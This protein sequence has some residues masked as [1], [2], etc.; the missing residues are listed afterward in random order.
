MHKLAEYPGLIADTA[1]ELNEIDL[2][3]RKLR[4]IQEGYEA[5]ADGIAAA[6][7]TLKNEQQRKAFKHQYLQNQGD[8]QD[9][10][11][12]IELLTRDRASLNTTL[13]RLRNEFAVAKL[14]YRMAIATKLAAIE[15]KELVDSTL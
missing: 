10:Q 6:D 13:E 3:V 8:Y 14:E 12:G 1:T 9:A 11:A 2:Q 15:D 5:I 4:I 7:P